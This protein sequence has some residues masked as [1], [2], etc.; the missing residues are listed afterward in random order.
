[1]NDRMLTEEN[2]LARRARD[3]LLEH[4]HLLRSRPLPAELRSNPLKHLPVSRLIDNAN[5]SSLEKRRLEVI[6]EVVDVFNS[7]TEAD[8]VFGKVAGGADGGVDRS[9]AVSSDSQYGGSETD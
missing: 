8:E 6:E 9:V 1:V 7:D 4:R 5:S 2:D 3:K